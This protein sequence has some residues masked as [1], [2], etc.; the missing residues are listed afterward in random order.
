M[1]FELKK[2]VEY[3]KLDDNKRIVL[4]LLPQYKQV[5]YADRFRTLIH[6]AAKDFLGKDFINCEIVDN[7]CIITVI[8]NTEE[9]NLKIIQTEV[10]DGLEL[11]MRL[12]GI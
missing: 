11:I 9:K 8:P 4:T 3:V 12:M 10:I 7:S 5:L 1:M 6:K 2:Y